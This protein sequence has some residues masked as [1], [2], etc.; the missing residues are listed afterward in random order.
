MSRMQLRW[1]KC[2][3]LRFH[4]SNDTLVF[5]IHIEVKKKSELWWLLMEGNTVKW[6]LAEQQSRAHKR[7]SVGR[8]YNLETAGSTRQE[9]ENTHQL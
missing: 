6:F 8:R 9:Q 7:S 3:N 4:A 5:W 2:Q 1:P